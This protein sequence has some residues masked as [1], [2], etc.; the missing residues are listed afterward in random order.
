MKVIEMFSAKFVDQYI[1]ILFTYKKITTSCM[2]QMFL[3]I[4]KYVIMNQI[5]FVKKVV[6]YVS[7]AN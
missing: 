1:K 4:L 2:V 6:H 7:I 3:V 5:M